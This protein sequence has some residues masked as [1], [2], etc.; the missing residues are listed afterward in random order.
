MGLNNVPMVVIHLFT[1][2]KFEF[3]LRDGL[4]GISNMNGWFRIHFAGE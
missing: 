3:V 2:I 1:Y 4:C